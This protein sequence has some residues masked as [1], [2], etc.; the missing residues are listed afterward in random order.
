MSKGLG[1]GTITSISSIESARAIGVCG[2]NAMFA[3]VV[4][5][6]ARV[7][8]IKKKE[9]APLHLNN[10]KVRVN[11]TCGDKFLLY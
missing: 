9:L 4:T 1:K 3:L 5:S 8:G 7:N 6:S 2:T 10:A 11:C